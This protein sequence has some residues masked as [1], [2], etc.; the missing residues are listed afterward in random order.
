MNILVINCGSSSIKYQ[1]FRI[2][3][4]Y[5]L[6]AKGL[7]ERIALSGSMLKHLRGDNKIS[8]E[9]NMPDHKAAM[10]AIEEILV[11]SRH[12]VLKNI[13]EI[14]GIGHRVVHG[15]ERFTGSTLISNEVLKAIEENCK[16]APLHNPPNI[17]GIQTCRE[18]LPKTPNVAV[19]DTAVHQTMPKKAYL[20]AL[21]MELYKKHGIRKYGFHGTSHGYVAREAAQ[22][23]NRPFEQTKI[24]TVHIGNGGSITAFS[25][26]KSV[27][28]S[29]GLTPL[30]G[31]VM[32][33]R[34]GDI[35]PAVVL[36]LQEM[37]GMTVAQTNDLLNK[38]SGLLGMC[39]KSDIRDIYAQIA[40]GD[41]NS[42]IALDVFEY[43]IIKYVGAYV[44]ALN[45]VDAIV[46][47]AGIGENNPAVRSRVL[48][49]FA[50]LGLEIDEGKN[51]ANEHIFS[52]P[53]SKVYA[54]MIP[55]NEE[56]VIARDT[57][58]ILRRTGKI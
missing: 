33:T 7:A 9:K 4:E 6:L 56:L 30:E 36:Y 2:D 13:N 53:S 25:N 51:N 28:T 46:F 5:K 22:L 17:V 40:A 21:P 24:I 42:Q 10:R 16:L 57:Y 35:D 12:G 58:E 45:G 52:K 27:D 49:N 50:Y 15:G 54:M 32:G 43:R 47:T 19:F 1:L 11:D 3:G 44:A 38:K 31:I 48:A 34:S 18:L 8:I 23:M 20:Y 37:L 26:G 14:D 29:M 55:T 39:G 41:E